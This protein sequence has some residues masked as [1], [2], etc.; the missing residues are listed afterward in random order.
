M[1]RQRNSPI[2]KFPFPKLIKKTSVSGLI[3]LL[4]WTIY[5]LAQNVHL[6]QPTKVPASNAPVELYS[7]Q[8]QDD[9]T[10]LYLHAIDSAK[11]SI[12]LVIYALM[13]DQ[14]IDALKKKSEE[15]IPLYIV[16]DAKA[17]PGI[18][19]KLPK[20]TI[21]KRFGDGLMHQ[22]ILII[23][24]KQIWLGSANLTYS[25]LHIH[26]NLVI[27]IDN[28]AL[29][30]A[31][32]DRAKSMDEDGGVSS[33]LMHRE[34]TAGPQNLELWVLPE[35]PNAVQRMIDLFRSAK[36]SIKVA[37]F[38][39]TRVDFTQELIAAA[40]RGVQVQAVLDRY[41]GKGASAKVV[42][43]FEQAGIPVRLSTGQGLLHYKFAYID[44]SI[45]VNGSANWTNSAFTR[46]DDYFIVVYPLTPDQQ[47]KM[48]QLWS[49]IYRKSAPPN[50]ATKNS[51]QKGK[52]RPHFDD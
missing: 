33:P 29:A 43:L 35:D 39:W 32:T 4:A 47:I 15:G 49:A 6:P 27:G 46:N 38:T 11:E 5:Q 7:N 17:S 8:T 22:K 18:S 16:C 52:W 36:K 2:P 50:E 23:D 19:R 41:A 20:A 26:G 24:N 42:R 37:M 10:R 3:I 21:V 1:A 31:L 30:Q 9:L 51:K 12:T 13:D 14:I 40:K 45:L 28:P 44:D 25:S 34:T 48:N